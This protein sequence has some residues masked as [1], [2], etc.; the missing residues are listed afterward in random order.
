ME[1]P[2]SDV[3]DQAFSHSSGHTSYQGSLGDRWWC[4]WAGMKLMRLHF[5]ESSQCYLPCQGENYRLRALN[6]T[7]E[8][9]SHCLRSCVLLAKLPDAPDLE[10]SLCGDDGN[11]DTGLPQGFN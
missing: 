8:V 6:H 10:T 3:R 1:V 5:L 9:V 11:Y 4:G 2:Q 7:G